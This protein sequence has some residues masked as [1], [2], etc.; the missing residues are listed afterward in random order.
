MRNLQASDVDRCVTV[1]PSLNLRWLRI[2]WMALLFVYTFR[3]VP[4]P[5][6]PVNAKL[7]ER[8]RDY[9]TAFGLLADL[10]LVPKGIPIL[11]GTQKSHV[12]SSESSQGEDIIVKT[13]MY[14]TG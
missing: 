11:E 1:W 4:R 10:T 8:S 6:V 3:H 2:R 7:S 13:C 12:G 14:A 5:K 9:A